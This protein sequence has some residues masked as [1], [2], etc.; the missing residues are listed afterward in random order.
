VRW[1]YG[2]LTSTSL[3]FSPYQRPELGFQVIPR[4]IPENSPEDGSMSLIV[5][6]LPSSY[7]STGN[8]SAILFQCEMSV[9]VKDENDEITQINT[10]H[11]IEISVTCKWTSVYFMQVF[12]II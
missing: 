6:Q 5:N 11:S 2:S 4:E 7:Y 9:V 12:S 8:S 3:I 10:N 1:K